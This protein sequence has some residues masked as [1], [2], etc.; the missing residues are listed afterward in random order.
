MHSWV[1]DHISLIS[2]GYVSLPARVSSGY[3]MEGMHDEINNSM[4]R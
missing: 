1:K 2:K 4:A 3:I